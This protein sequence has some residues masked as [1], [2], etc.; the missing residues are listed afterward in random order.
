VLRGNFPRSDRNASDRDVNPNYV[1]NGSA[2]G[3]QK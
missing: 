2:P 3:A 1:N